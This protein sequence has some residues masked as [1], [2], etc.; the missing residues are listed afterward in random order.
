LARQ[1]NLESQKRVNQ[2]ELVWGE[3][4]QARWI[5]EDIEGPKLKEYQS[6]CTEKLC[7]ME[8]NQIFTKLLQKTDSQRLLRPWGDTSASFV[9][10]GQKR[11]FSRGLH[12][13]F[14][15]NDLKDF[16]FGVHWNQDQQFK[17]PENAENSIWKMTTPP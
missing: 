10:F 2:R 5:D 3:L 9:F 6:P 8:T 13:D 11:P 15:F 1:K 14:I 17:H 12:Q 4:V 7:F 16:L